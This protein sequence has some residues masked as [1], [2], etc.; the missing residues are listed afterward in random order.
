MV[1]YPLK[2]YKT[3]GFC[4]Q[5]T[6]SCIAGKNVRNSQWLIFDMRVV[7]PCVFIFWYS[8]YFAGWKP[9]ITALCGDKSSLAAPTTDALLRSIQKTRLHSIG[10]SFAIQLERHCLAWKTCSRAGASENSAPSGI[11]FGLEREAVAK[12]HSEWQWLWHKGCQGS[13]VQTGFWS[14]F[15]HAY[16]Q[17]KSSRNFMC[18]LQVMEIKT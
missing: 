11:G 10:N 4:F 12:F 3:S 14:R 18:S 16:F 15:L 1:L 5:C 13:G 6:S 7:Y 8:Q 2:W 9:W 17:I